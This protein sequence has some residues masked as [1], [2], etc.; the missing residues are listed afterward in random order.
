V[1]VQY[2]GDLETRRYERKAEPTSRAEQSRKKGS[3]SE[4]KYSVIKLERNLKVKWMSRQNKQAS[5]HP[6]IQAS[7]HPSG[8][9]V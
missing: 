3:R 7:K 8:E 9:A 1:D 6:S 2:L 4:V 5:K